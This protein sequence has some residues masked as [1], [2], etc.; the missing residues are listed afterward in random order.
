MTLLITAFAAIICTIL[1][2]KNA[3]KNEMKIGILCWMY[4]GASIMWLVDAIFEY[5]ELKAEYF[6]P[7]PADMLND[8]YLGLSVVA[9]GLIIWL[10]I[11]LVKDP[12]GVVKAALFQKKQ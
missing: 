2:Y 5:A 10:V 4:W 7:N 8:F 6:T 3:P 9:L 1:W 12:K 11:L